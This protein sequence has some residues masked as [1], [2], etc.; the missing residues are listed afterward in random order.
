MN[1]KLFSCSLILLIS[2]A[3]LSAAHG[4]S[5]DGMDHGH[6]HEEVNPSFKYS[7]QA[8]EQVKKQE[9]PSAQHHHHGHDCHG[10]SHGEEP[11]AKREVPHQEKL[12]QKEVPT[13]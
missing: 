9:N 3:C 8:N 13:G 4:H 1:L 2:Y 7:K 5:H 12:K 11:R 6:S 10:H